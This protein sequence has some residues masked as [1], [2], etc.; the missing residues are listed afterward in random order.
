MSRPFFTP[1]D[2]AFAKGAPMVPFDGRRT[3][4]ALEYAALPKYRRLLPSWLLKPNVGVWHPSDS[5]IMSERVESLALSGRAYNG[6]GL[7]PV[8]RRRHM[9]GRRETPPGQNIAEAI[10]P[11][12]L[13]I[14][15]LLDS[16]RRHRRIE[17]H[18]SGTI[19][20]TPL[21]RF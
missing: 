7:G 9:P 5:P 8:R 19:E 4:G 14:F 6:R 13:I 20:E 1:D 12:V 3:L 17:V 10:T 21:M 18:A 11:A 2:Q 16:L 15:R